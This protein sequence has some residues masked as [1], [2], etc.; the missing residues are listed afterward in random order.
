MH[1]RRWCGRSGIEPGGRIGV[2]GPSGIAGRSA[3]FVANE[4]I[5]FVEWRSPND[6]SADRIV[7]A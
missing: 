4:H 7:C 1:G 5:L 2:V 3:F 6:E